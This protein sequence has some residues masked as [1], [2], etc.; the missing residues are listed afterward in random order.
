[1]E[2]LNGIMGM[3]GNLVIIGMIAWFVLKK[4]K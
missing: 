2:T 1:M 3:V 4:N